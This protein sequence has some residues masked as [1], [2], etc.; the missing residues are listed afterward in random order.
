MNLDGAQLGCAA[1]IAFSLL[2]GQ[3]APGD[4]RLPPDMMSMIEH[5]AILEEMIEVCG[6]TRPDLLGSIR[7]AQAAWWQ[8]NAVRAALLELLDTAETSSASKEALARYAALHRRLENE[9]QAPETAGQN[10]E[11]V[12]DRM[13]SGRL[14]YAKPPRPKTRAPMS[15]R[16]SRYCPD[17]SSDD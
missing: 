4:L 11:W 17:R 13:T 6:R 2:V 9:L 16:P 15:S 5:V 14:D 8:R 3:D 1:V 10:R 12:L 7:R